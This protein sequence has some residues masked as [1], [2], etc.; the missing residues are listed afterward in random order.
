MGHIEKYLAVL[1]VRPNIEPDIKINTEMWGN[2]Y[3]DTSINTLQFP[4]PQIKTIFSKESI[5]NAVVELFNKYGVVD[6][7]GKD[8]QPI[9][10]ATGFYDTS[11]GYSIPSDKTFT[12]DEVIK[13]IE[14]TEK[15]LNVNTVGIW[16]NKTE[17]LID[18]H[19]LI[20]KFKNI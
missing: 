1:G 11:A 19:K 13:I 12:L 8:I 18:K 15:R 7:Y 3:Q 9:D 4:L 17:E 2:I 5:E 6:K 20:E 10:T 16:E 14:S